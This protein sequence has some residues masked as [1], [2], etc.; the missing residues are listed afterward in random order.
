M[1]SSVSEPQWNFFS[2]PDSGCAEHKVRIGCNRR[3]PPEL[4]RNSALAQELLSHHGTGC[5]QHHG[6]L[7]WLA[8]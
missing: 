6:T 7:V 3:L 8:S 1:N 2:P 4:E 5:E